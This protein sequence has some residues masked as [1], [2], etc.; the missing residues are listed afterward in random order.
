MPTEQ[1]GPFLRLHGPTLTSRA[2]HKLFSAHWTLD[3]LKVDAPHLGE[4]KPPHFAA[5]RIERSLHFF[6][7][8]L[9]GAWHAGYFSPSLLRIC[10]MTSGWQRRR[11]SQTP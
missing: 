1:V 11:M 3:T 9:P 4:I 2:G 10:A 6:K 5:Y 7:I 8:D